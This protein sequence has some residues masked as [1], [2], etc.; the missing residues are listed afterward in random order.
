MLALWLSNNV[1]VTPFYPIMT[2]KLSAIECT[3]ATAQCVQLFG[4][5]QLEKV[6]SAIQVR[7][8]LASGASPFI[9]NR[10]T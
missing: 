2:G 4:P 9:M 1:W 6:R 7:T 3:L 10:A 8:I 5:A